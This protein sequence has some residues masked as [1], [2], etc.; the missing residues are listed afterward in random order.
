M[1]PNSLNNSR[2]PSSGDE[3]QLSPTVWVILI[4]VGVFGLGGFVF[5][6]GR[7]FNVSGPAKPTRTAS[8]PASAEIEI[9]ST[10]SLS[11]ESGSFTIW[12]DPV[13]RDLIC[14]RGEVY[15]LEYT[16]LSPDSELLTDLEVSKQFV[17]SDGSGSFYLS[18]N[19]DI[20]G[21]RTTGT[22][23]ITGGEGDYGALSGAGTLEGTYLNDDLVVDSYR[24]TVT[25]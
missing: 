8:R 14:G 12:G 23:Q 19:V 18:V 3:P 22:W 17:C 2:R 20:T 11:E 1:K 9:N 25:G 15:D 16:D 10:V 13:N 7:L 5:N 21:N 24:G 4:L 6:L